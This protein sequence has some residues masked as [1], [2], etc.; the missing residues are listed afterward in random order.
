MINNSVLFRGK[1]IRNSKW[2]YGDLINNYDGRVFIG[3]VLVL[4]NGYEGTSY[5]IYGAEI[6]FDEVDPETVGQFTGLSDRNGNKIFGGDILDTPRW[7][8]TY[9]ANVNAG[10]GMQAGWYIQRDDIESC[11]E[12]WCTE[13][14]EVLGNIYDN[15]ELL[16][17]R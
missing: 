3:K 10:F 15:P 12:L 7:V 4:A 5:D 6:G 16:E 13:N 1:C 8:V 9:L 14:H 2:I 17:R 11:K